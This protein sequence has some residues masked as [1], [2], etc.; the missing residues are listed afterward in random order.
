ME[1]GITVAEGYLYRKQHAE[2][3]MFSEQACI[4]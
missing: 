2:A 3:G 4:K 1:I